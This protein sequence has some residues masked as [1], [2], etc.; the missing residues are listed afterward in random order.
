MPSDSWQIYTKLSNF[1][2]D[3]LK[4]V[5]IWDTLLSTCFWHQGPHMLWP[6]K[7]VVCKMSAIVGWVIMAWWRH[8]AWH[9]R[10]CSTLVKV[11]ACCRMAPSHYL[12][13]CWLTISKILWHSFQGDICLNTRFID[14]Q[15]VFEIY[16][17]EITIASLRQC[18]KLSQTSCRSS[19]LESPI[20]NIKLK[21]NQQKVPSP[22]PK[23][24]ASDWRTC[25]NCQHC[26]QGIMS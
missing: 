18:L 8:M 24:L 4:T 25:G 10:C 22:P 21:K 5:L 17:F 13:Q 9:Q 1:K 12:N 15:I 23:L 6:F 2:V 7:N 19:C 26:S 16:T 11:T 20:I 14:P 3:L